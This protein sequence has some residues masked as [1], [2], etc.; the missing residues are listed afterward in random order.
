[1]PA[2]SEA[3]EHYTTLTVHVPISVVDR[4]R[5]YARRR[6]K[7]T[8]VSEAIRAALDQADAERAAQEPE[9]AEAAS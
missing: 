8:F 9:P 5:P 7:A 4:L 6:A 3:P 2:E 1:M